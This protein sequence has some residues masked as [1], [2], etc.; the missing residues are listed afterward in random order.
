MRVTEPVLLCVA[1]LAAGCSR[2]KEPPGARHMPAATV[3]VEVVEAKPRIATEEVVATVRSKLQAAVEAKVSGRVDRMLAVPGEH[4]KQGDLLA[5]IDAREL[6]AKLDQALAVREQTASDL[7]RSTELLEKKAIAQSDFDATQSRA[8]VAEAAV[9]EAKTM[10]DYSKITA[11]FDG[12]ITRKLAD[13]GDLAIPGRPLV[14]MEDP[15]ALRL[16]A[17]VPDALVGNLKLGQKL[18]VQIAQQRGDLEGVVSE[19]APAS[20]PASRTSLVK[21]DLPAVPG[22]RTG[23]FG[24][25]SVPVGE[26]TALRVPVSAVVQRGQMEIV[27]VVAD[28]RAHL[29]LVKTG[30]RVGDEIELISGVDAGETVVVDGAGTL[31]DGQPVNVQS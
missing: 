24:H 2:H 12:V 5:E 1:L 13:V 25:V 9:M 21:L 31:V 11:P 19:I 14:E 30:R 28:Q 18:R 22:L 4:V 15:T 17:D 3:R 23:Q 27:F 6:K 20:D 26:T 7:K 10:L 16:E 29:R 8:R